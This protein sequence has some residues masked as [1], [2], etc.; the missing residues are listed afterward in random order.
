MQ[1]WALSM[2][3]VYMM[4]PLGT[5]RCS[6]VPMKRPEKSLPA[7]QLSQT[8]PPRGCNLTPAEVLARRRHGSAAQE[9]SHIRKTSEMRADGA[10]LAAKLWLAI[11]LCLLPSVFV[12]VSPNLWCLSL[13]HGWRGLANGTTLRTFNERPQAEVG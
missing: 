9:K 4:E 2:A 11:V 13:S 5:L 6:D 3:Q 8:P 1:T 10:D 12:R 7:L